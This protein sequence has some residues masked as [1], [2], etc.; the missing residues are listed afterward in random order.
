[1]IHSLQVLLA[2]HS[3]LLALLVSVS[4]SHLAS[5]SLVRCTR[6]NF[7]SVTSSLLGRSAYPWVDFDGEL[8]FCTVCREF[9]H[10]IA[11][12]NVSLLKGSKTFLKFVLNDHHISEAHSISMGAKAAK[13]THLGIIKARMNTQQVTNLKVLFNSAYCM[14]QRNWSFRDF[15]YL[16]ILQAKNGLQL[17]SNY[18]ITHGA[19]TFV[20]LGSGL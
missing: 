14:A 12:K 10:L 7:G 13:E 4:E 15:E 19:K 18:Q 9:Q 2:A 20:I 8:M 1:M 17:M 6:V 16:C 5:K 11:P 3:K